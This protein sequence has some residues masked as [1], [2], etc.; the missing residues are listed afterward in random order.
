MKAYPIPLL[1]LGCLLLTLAAPARA[2]EQLPAE[3]DHAYKPLQLTL[4][5]DGSKYI[6][7]IMWHQFW[8]RSTEN[9]PGTV[10]LAGAPSARSFD[11]GL[12][13]SRLLALAQVSPRFL[14]LTH[15]GINNQT[16]ANGGAP[17][18][19]PKKPGLFIHDAWTEYQLVPKKLYIGAGLH[20]WNGISRLSSASTLNFMTLDAPIHNWATI[21]MT[22]QFA[23]QYGIYAK[24]QLGGFDYRLALNKPFAFGVAAREGE[25]VNRLNDEVALQGYFNYQFRERESNKLPFMV[26][27]YLGAKSLFNLGFGF[28]YHPR[29]T[30]SLQGGEL[31]IH[32]MKL[33][34]ADLFW[35]QPLGKG[36][37][38]SLYSTL[39][40]YD[41]GPN[42]IR[43][44]G[45]MNV[46][47]MPAQDSPQLELLS[48]NGVG[49]TQPTIGTGTISYT[50]LGLALPRMKNGAQ[51]MPYATYTRKD[52]ERLNG[53]S[54]QY[55]LGLNYF[56]NGHHAKLTLQYSTRPIYD[57]GRNLERYAGELILQTHIF[58]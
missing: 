7:F 38:I 4:S 8:V 36:T 9:N 29:A 57:L 35:E 31:Q 14:I 15:F 55:D 11:V 13:R 5:E 44:I 23:R 17:G 33:L 21:E 51:L 1:L 58:L 30:H 41:F 54:N 53:G 37:A 20:Y 27:S 42:Y 39:Y 34:G 49:N 12:R 50:Q 43:N 24:G 32:D 40:A 26:G 19:G 3:P 47:Q 22:D 2:Q 52:F 16:F 48:F 28:H 6:R 46:G 18:A 10:D 25:A 56:L 45:I